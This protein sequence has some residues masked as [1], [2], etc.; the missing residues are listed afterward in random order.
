MSANK[1]NLIVKHYQDYLIFNNSHRKHSRSSA[2]YSDKSFNIV[3]QIRKWLNKQKYANVFDHFENFSEIIKTF[4][5]NNKKSISRN[6]IHHALNTALVC[7]LGLL[8][9]F[10][11]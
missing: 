6:E 10:A 7:K 9:Y 11:F 3:N 5:I 2:Y 8:D 4:W 1:K